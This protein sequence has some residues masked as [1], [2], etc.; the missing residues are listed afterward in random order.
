MADRLLRLARV[1]AH[2]ALDW[3]WQ[4]NRMTRT[5]AYR[6]LAEVLEISPEEADAKAHIAMLDKDQCRKVIKAFNALRP[7]KM[8]HH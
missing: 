7:W 8:P 1:K 6:K 4:T 2:K 3:A 5:E